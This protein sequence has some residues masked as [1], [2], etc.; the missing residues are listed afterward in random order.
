MKRKL[1]K[2]VE[3]Q[4]KEQGLRQVSI[5]EL[6]YPKDHSSQTFKAQKNKTTK[7]EQEDGIQNRR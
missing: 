2:T 1:K 3:E 4:L 6:L 5:N 7:G